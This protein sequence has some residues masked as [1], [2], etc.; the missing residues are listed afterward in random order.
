MLRF[1]KWMLPVVVAAGF[2]MS[3]APVVK[4]ADEGAVIKGTVVDKDGKAVAEATVR[5]T[6]PR[7]EGQQGRPEPL[8]TATTDKDGKFTLTI[9]KSKVADGDYTVGSY[10]RE[11]RTGAR[12][13]VTIKDGKPEPAEVTLKLAAMPQRGQ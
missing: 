3:M 6:K 7:V 13:K 11:A 1:F 5:L 4:A 9:D 12:E 2:V 8:A 10:N